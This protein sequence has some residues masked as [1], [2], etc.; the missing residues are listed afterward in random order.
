MAK[1]A[2]FSILFFCLFIF[3]CASTSGDNPQEKRAA[4]Q[5]M[6]Q[7]VLN[8][9]YKVKPHAKSEILAAPGYA[10]F[11]NANINLIFASFGGG[12]GVVENQKNGANTYMKMGEVGLGLGLGI[13][14]F[15]A[16]FVFKNE[17]ALR[18]FVDKGWEFGGSV[19]AA[20]KAGEKG[21]AVGGEAVIDDVTIYQLTESGLAL[22]ATLKGTKF[23]KDKAL[24]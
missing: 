20:A 11:S 22:Q 16:V 6:K 2:F 24:N 13:K 17:D 18:Q 21:A 4:V 7:E 23:W 9:L 12:Y 15:R 5:E 8:D 1:K 14:D 3:G 19:D 10:V